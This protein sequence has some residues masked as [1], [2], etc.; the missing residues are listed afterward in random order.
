MTEVSVPIGGALF[1][2]DGRAPQVLIRIVDGALHADKDAGRDGVQIAQPLRD[3]T[4][5]VEPRPE[6]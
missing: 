3:R 6:E 5:L 2:T 4:P 1:P